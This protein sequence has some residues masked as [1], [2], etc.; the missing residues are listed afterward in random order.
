MQSPTSRV[1]ISIALGIFSGS[2]FFLFSN[3][4]KVIQE[5][6]FIWSYIGSLD[7]GTTQLLTLCAL[8]PTFLL[9]IP[10]RIFGVGAGIIALISNLYCVL[11]IFVGLFI[12][13]AQVSSA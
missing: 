2:L 13:L 1:S 4:D 10:L 12:T 8:G 9:F 5:I 7:S 6:S 3:I 11:S